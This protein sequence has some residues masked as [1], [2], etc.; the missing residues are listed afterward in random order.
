[1]ICPNCHKTLR[2][3]NSRQKTDS[4]RKRWYECKDDSCGYVGTSI[5]VMDEEKVASVYKKA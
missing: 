4:K 3:T 2:V 1:M 5:E